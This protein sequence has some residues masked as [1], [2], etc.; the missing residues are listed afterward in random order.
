M[1]RIE[2]KGINKEQYE[3]IDSMAKQIMLI[4]ACAPVGINVAISP[5]Q[6]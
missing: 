1:H 2:K 3:C 6:I 5:I 4:A